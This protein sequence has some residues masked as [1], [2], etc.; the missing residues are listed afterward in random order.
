MERG[1]VLGRPHRVLL[2]Y[3]FT[4]L[5]KLPVSLLVTYSY[6]QSTHF[7]S[8]DSNVTF[9]GFIWNSPVSYIGFPDDSGKRICLPIQ[10]MQKM[11]VRSLGR[12]DPLEESMAT[13]SSILVWE[14][15]WTEEPGGL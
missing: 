8:P 4:P 13:H 15:S 7:E 1:S 14:N 3:K 5:P 12:E 9:S 11:W 6:F 2:S 10:E